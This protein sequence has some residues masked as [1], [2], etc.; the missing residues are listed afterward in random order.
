M[1]PYILV[2]NN[3]TLKKTKNIGP[4]SGAFYYDKQK[5]YSITFLALLNCMILSSLENK[6]S[7]KNR[8]A[9]S[10]SFRYKV[11]SQ[12]DVLKIYFKNSTSEVEKCFTNTKTI[13]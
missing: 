5:Y 9:I 8:Y 10:N 2:L 12:V 13:I 7:D 3:E 4:Q 11:Y 6:G 1:L